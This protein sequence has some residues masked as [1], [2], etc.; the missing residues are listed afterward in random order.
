MPSPDASSKEENASKAEATDSAKEDKRLSSA[1]EQKGVAGEEGALEPLKN[2]NP[3]PGAGLNRDSKRVSMDAPTHAPTDSQSTTVDPTHSTPEAGHS[4]ED[5]STHEKSID[6]SSTKHSSDG[7]GY[8]GD[9]T[10]EDHTWKEIVR[11]KEEMFWAR[12][13][14]MR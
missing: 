12:V 9:A 8:I 13:E 5:S 11:L 3:F 2:S 14:G 6:T 7:E 10:W 4:S 1:L